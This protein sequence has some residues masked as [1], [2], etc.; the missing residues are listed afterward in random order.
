[1][2]KFIT[3]NILTV[4]QINEETF[5]EKMEKEKEKFFEETIKKCMKHINTLLPTLNKTTLEYKELYRDTCK[6]H[7]LT[8]DIENKISTVQKEIDDIVDNIFGS[9]EPIS[10]IE[11]EI[12]GFKEKMEKLEKEKER[13][14]ANAR[15]L[16]H[17]LSP[18]LDNLISLRKEISEALIQGQKSLEEHMHHLTGTIQRTEATMKDSNRFI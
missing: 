5:K 12:V 14:K 10:I 6:P 18:K 17:K 8:Q 7:L 9:F 13:I 11:Q 15:E 2:S 1:M 3:G 4:D 16:K